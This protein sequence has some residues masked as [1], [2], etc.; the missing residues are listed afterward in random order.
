MFSRKDKGEPGEE[1]PEKDKHPIVQQQ[2][3]AVQAPLEG[4]PILDWQNEKDRETIRAL[5][6]AYFLDGETSA[7][8]LYETMI[9]PNREQKII[10][11]TPQVISS[12]CANWQKHR[13][14]D[15][16]APFETTVSEVN[17]M[18]QDFE[19]KF[20]RNE[21]KYDELAANFQAL[22]EL[23]K[24]EKADEEKPK[25]PLEDEKE[26]REFEENL[27]KRERELEIIKKE[28]ALAKK[29]SKTMKSIKD[30]KGE[31]DKHR[32]DIEKL[33]DQVAK[34]DVGEEE[35]PD[36]EVEEDQL[37]SDCYHVLK[38]CQ[39]VMPESFTNILKRQGGRSRAT[40]EK[41]LEGM[42]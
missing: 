21:E 24:R 14:R 38:R 35:I 20:A 15:E 10:N 27:S 34:D 2:R 29:S 1:A 23:T 11:I 6:Y 13:K 33:K 4:K 32:R 3:P 7:N 17:K 9:S 40:I 5:L 26:L 30:N 39:T 25:E 42:E 31:L 37:L 19:E 12:Q 28:L 8:V 36:M 16:T 22:M 18:R 41:K